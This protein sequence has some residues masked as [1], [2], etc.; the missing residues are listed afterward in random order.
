M[1]ILVDSEYLY[2]LHDRLRAYNSCMYDLGHKN[3]AHDLLGEAEKV[4]KLL[5]DAG[6]FATD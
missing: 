1:N 5:E 2:R 3:I 6:F 4:Y